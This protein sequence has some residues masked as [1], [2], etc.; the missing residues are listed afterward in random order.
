MAFSNHPSW[1]FWLWCALSAISC[2]Y[3]VE[4][5][6]KKS[7]YRSHQKG[8]DICFRPWDWWAPD[9]NSWITCPS[10]RHT[11][12]N[13]FRNSTVFSGYAIVCKGLHWRKWHVGNNSLR[14]CFVQNSVSKFTLRGSAYSAK[15]RGYFT[16]S[17]SSRGNELG[18]CCDWWD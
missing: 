8:W 14:S 13:L 7:C 2:W 5:W 17:R 15:H 3:S 12:G 9:W 18:K 11:R 6:N 1:H 10:N 4:W 16:V